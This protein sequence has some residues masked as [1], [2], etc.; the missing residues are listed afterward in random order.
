MNSNETGALRSTY[1]TN[2]AR[3]EW[4][5][6]LIIVGLLVEIAAVFVF[7]KPFLESAI[8]VF[9]NVLIVAGVWGE[10]LFSRRAK[11]AG[12][13]IVA[14][15]NARA[16]MAQMELKRLSEPRKFDVTHFKEIL[17]NP[18]AVKAKVEIL[19]VRECSD[20]AFL[21]AVLWGALTACK[22][23]VQKY[24]PLV[25]P[26]GDKAHLPTAMSVGA[27]PYGVS[28]VSKKPAFLPFESSPSGDLHFAVGYALGTISGVVGQP[29][30][31]MA[32]DV[33]RVVVAPRP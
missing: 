7:Q 24:G 20:C 10:I 29:D 8:A 12:D 11:E 18:K 33:V 25:E 3:A 16:A 1:E 31:A 27:L 4:I 17:E 2:S 6:S 26:A 21:A 14:Q 22:W 23:E 9:A 32:D 19:Y 15:A 13:G 28:V 5:A 30:E